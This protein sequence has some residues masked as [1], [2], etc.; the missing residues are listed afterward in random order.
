MSG[1]EPLIRLRP[2]SPNAHAQMFGRGR[3]SCLRSEAIAKEA[4]YAVGILAIGSDIE[5]VGFGFFHDCS[6]LI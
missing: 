5:M 1:Y 4:P 2:P 6:F 3:P